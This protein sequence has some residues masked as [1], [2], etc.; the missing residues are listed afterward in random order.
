ML[1]RELVICSFHGMLETGEHRGLLRREAHKYAKGR[2]F[3][4]RGLSSDRI[5]VGYKPR[6]LEDK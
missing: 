5:T 1:V 6:K 3:E 4:I 2:D